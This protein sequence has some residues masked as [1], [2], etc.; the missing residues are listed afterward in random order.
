M[1]ENNNY[2]VT[3]EELLP[4]LKDFNQTGIMSEKLGLMVFKISSGLA[5]KGNFSNYT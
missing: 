2:Y 4:E 3:N 5:N 1:S